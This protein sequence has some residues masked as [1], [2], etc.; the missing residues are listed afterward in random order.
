MVRAH[1]VFTPGHVWHIT[2]RCHARS[3]LLRFQRDRRRWLYW[4][5]EACDRLV[6]DRGLGE[7]PRSIALAAGRTAWEYNR[8]KGRAGAFWQDRYH[9]T[10][11]DT[12]S[13][14]HRCL[15]YID[16]N[17][18]RAGAV[19][20]PR[21]WRDSGFVE[22]Q[23]GRQRYRILDVSALLELT[24]HRSVARLRKAL[25]E[26]A[27]RSSRDGRARIRE[28]EWTEPLAV[29]QPAFLASLQREMGH[30][31]RYRTIIE[32]TSEGCALRE[33]PAG[34][35]RPDSAARING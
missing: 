27:D 18:V 26:Q 14:L 1:R 19:A 21:E 9:A 12:E 15:G 24:G 3:F 2:H 16:M 7:I 20:H 34:R 6:R 8:R 10:A 35:Y 17:M 30:A 29:G 4:L 25:C 31:A 11:V 23:Q 33:S 5:R 13:H 32:C 22:L 28:P